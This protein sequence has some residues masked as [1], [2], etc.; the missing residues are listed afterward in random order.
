MNSPQ[1]QALYSSDEPITE[2]RVKALAEEL[3]KE[4]KG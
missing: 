4:E 3:I 1:T 2:Q